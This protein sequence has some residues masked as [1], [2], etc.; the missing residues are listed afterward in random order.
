MGTYVKWSALMAVFFLLLFTTTSEPLRAEGVTV[1]GTLKDLTGKPVEGLIVRLFAL[2][3]GSGPRSRTAVVDAK[4]RFRFK[5]LA[6]GEHFVSVRSERPGDVFNTTF[7][8]AA[9]E[10][11]ENRLDLRLEKTS[12]A[13]RVTLK[14]TGESPA[15]SGKFV[16]LSLRQLVP[17]DGADGESIDDTGGRANSAVDGSF[18]FRGFPPGRYRMYVTLRDHRRIQHDF[19]VKK[20]KPVVGL[21]FAIEPLQAGTI[22]L[23]VTDGDGRPVEGLYLSYD[24]GDG[25]SHSLNPKSTAPGMYVITQLE[26]GTWEVSLYREDLG[27]TRISVEVVEGETFDVEVKLGEGITSRKKG[28]PEKPAVKLPPLEVPEP[29]TGDFEPEA[30]HLY[31]LMVETMQEAKTLSWVS[32]YRRGSDKYGDLPP[33]TYAIWLKKPNHVRLEASLDGSVRGILVGDGRYFWTYWPPGRIQRS[34]EA[35]GPRAKEYKRTKHISYIKKRSPQ[36]RHSIGHET[37]DLGAGLGMPILDPSTFHGYTDSLQAYIDGVRSGGTEEFAGEECDV[38]EVS[39][40][41]GQRTW[42][43]WLSKKDHLPRRLLQ[44]IRARTRYYT[45][46]IWSDVMI[47]ADIPAK[48]FRWKPG[49]NWV[50]FRQPNVREGLLKTG[51]PAPDFDLPLHGGGRFRLS[52]QK[53]KVIWFYL[54]RAG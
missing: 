50:Q 48:K 3:E 7:P 9:I 17:R 25:V 45:E 44:V 6:P 34:W 10:E 37:N 5:G 12:V 1:A 18:F 20:G 38:I 22:R 54:W 35:S 49:R 31:D 41:K 8:R 40:M 51:K 46:E 36:G 15:K 33:C 23:I 13:G 21:E 26:A 43:L 39:I 11:G 32:I 14:E 2:E 28:V 29:F 27:S 30:R 24:T 16:S 19:E 4:G 53:G 52:E 47:D 42:R